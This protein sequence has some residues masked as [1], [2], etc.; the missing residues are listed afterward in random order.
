MKRIVHIICLLFTTLGWTQEEWSL[1]KCLSHA[2]DNNLSI[3]SKQVDLLIAEIQ[4]KQT[5]LN[6]LPTLNAGG[7]HGFNWGQSIDP[8]TNQ[9]ATDRIRTNNLYAGSRWTLFSGL[10]N[11]YLQQQGELT[12]Q[13][14]EQEIA[15]A[16]RNLKV[17]IVAAYMQ[18]VLN[19]FLIEA[20]NKQL[21]YALKSEELVKERFDLGYVTRYDVLA[22]SGQLSMDSITLVQA[23]NNKA[24]SLLLLKQLLA[25]NEDV[26][27]ELPDIKQLE[28]QEVKGL[29]SENQMENNPEYELAK[30]QTALKEQQLKLA[31]AQLMPTVAINSSIGSGYS[32][33]NK[34]LV[35][36]EFLPKPFDV[37][38]QENFYQSS[39]LTL[40]VPIFNNGRV[41]SEIKIAEAELTKNEIEQ[42]I[43]FQQLHNQFQQLQNEIRNEKVKVEALK[44]VVDGM[45]ER[46]EAA[47]EQYTAG[48]LN[49]QN[50]IDLRNQL[51]STQADYYTALITLRFKEKMMELF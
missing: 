34:E 28:L 4:Q 45:N 47:T 39:V 18:V 15:I 1:E 10:K 17:D 25:I 6:A 12:V 23:K 20:A 43:M 30:T 51:F 14:T 22:M 36:S 13:A 19:H 40:T 41:R 3:K 27:I 7:T 37:Q 11:Y 32:G 49:V 26:V 16:Q 48:T 21:E 8:F 46:F 42:E 9:F 5:R 33:N 35:G 29:P 31:K 38:L 24:H 2:T 44:R 50:Y